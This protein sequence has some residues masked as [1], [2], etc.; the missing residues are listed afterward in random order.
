MGSGSWPV[1]SRDSWRRSLWG[2]VSLGDDR[3]VELCICGHGIGLHMA[4]SFAR[5]G[6]QGPEE[7]F[8][9]H[10]LQNASPRA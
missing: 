10:V 6:P 1:R 2:T 7:Y 3:C 8:G 4:S 5:G 9:L